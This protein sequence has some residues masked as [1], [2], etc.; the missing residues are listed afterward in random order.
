MCFFQKKKKTKIKLVFQIR[1]SLDQ[2]W[3]KFGQSLDQVWTKF[4]P[5]LDQVWT[6]SGPRV[7][8]V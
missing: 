5:S 6:K 1:S 2:N 7:D 3:T 8:Q 4:R